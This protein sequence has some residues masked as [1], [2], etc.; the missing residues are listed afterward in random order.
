MKKEMEICRNVKEKRK[1]MQNLLNILPK[2]QNTDIRVEF[3]QELIPIGLLHVQ[4]IFEDETTQLVGKRYKRNNDSAC[5]RWG[6]QGGSIY[7]GEQKVPVYVPRVRNKKGKG[8]VNLRAYELLKK[9]HHLDKGAFKKILYGISCR[10]YE[11]AGERIPEAFGLSASTISRRYIKAS[12]QKLKE[13]QERRLDKY[14]IV[15]IFI[16]GKI[17]KEDELIVA[18]GI[19]MEGKK[20]ILGFVQSGTENAIVCQEFLESLIE[21]GLRIDNGILCVVDGSKG[22]IKGVKKAYGDKVLIQRCQWHKRE[23]VMSYL[24]QK[25]QDTFSKKLQHAFDKPTYVEAKEAIKK[26]RE[27]LVLINES[28]VRSLDEGVEEVLTLHRLGI[29]K[30]LGRSFKTTNCIESIFSCVEQTTGKIDYWRN[31]NQKQRWLASSL[32]VIE[33]RL[34]RICGYKYLPELRKAIRKEMEHPA[35]A[36]IRKLMGITRSPISE[37]MG[38]LDFA[39]P[40]CSVS[41][42]VCVG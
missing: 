3:I 40:P 21:R 23:N 35:L 19:T 25:E 17:F 36:V 29:F 10:R 31:S 30:K 22:L 38:I 27:E 32:S 39:L 7:L 2:L 8:E 4:E 18:L 5:Y 41:E 9:P 33:P 34:N 14:D 42:V 15:A 13:S 11:E 26:V 20:V 1:D 12:S 6:R 16:D 24:P 28:A 37:T